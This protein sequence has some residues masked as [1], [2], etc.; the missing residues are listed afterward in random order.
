MHSF[1]T[2]LDLA[3]TEEEKYDTLLQITT[4]APEARGRYLALG[5]TF[6]LT[7]FSLGHRDQRVLWLVCKI[8][9]LN[10]MGCLFSYILHCT[11]SC[12]FTLLCSHNIENP[13]FYMIKLVDAIFPDL[14]VQGRSRLMAG[15]L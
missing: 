5:A 1:A 9:C 14:Y 6:F 11:F 13:V 15:F 2:A 4:V 10:F 7:G 12:Y 8:L 3:E